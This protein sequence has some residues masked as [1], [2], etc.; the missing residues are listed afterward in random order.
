MAWK[1]VL[2]KGEHHP[3]KGEQG[4]KSK[5]SNEK[6]SKILTVRLTEDQFNVMKN[7]LKDSPFNSLSDLTRAAIL[8]YLM[9]IDADTT[10]TPPVSKNQLK[11]MMTF[12]TDAD[13]ED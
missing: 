3:Q 12:A 7:A 11:L 4:F 1:T 2:E 6:V 10:L 13:S 5:P 8:D 9:S